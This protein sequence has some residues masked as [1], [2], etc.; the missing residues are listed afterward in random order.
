MVK[1]SR[2]GREV[3]LP[4]RKGGVNKICHT[5]HSHI[6]MGCFKL[7]LGLCN[8]IEALIKR[9]WWDK[10]VIVGKSIELNGMT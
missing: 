4:S 5:S 10:E 1:A 6:Y 3:T 2:M 8:E 7:P 9:F